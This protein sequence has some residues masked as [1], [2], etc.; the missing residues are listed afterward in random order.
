MSNR[1][2]V[3]PDVQITP[4]SGMAH[5][6]WLAKYIVDKQPETIVCLGD[7]Y[8]LPSLCSYD[9]GTK[10]AEGRRIIADIE[11]GNAAMDVLLAPLRMLQ[12]RQLKNK[13]KVYKPRMVF[14]LGN[15]AG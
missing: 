10:R 12:R 3:I 15:A 8:D 13:K 5:V 11:A 9:K 1:V 6:A 7:W 4:D 2:L 14:T